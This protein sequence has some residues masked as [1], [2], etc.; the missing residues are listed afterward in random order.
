MNALFQFQVRDVDD[1]RIRDFSRKDIHF[2]VMEKLIDNA[3]LLQSD[4]RF[5]P[6]KLNQRNYADATVG[7]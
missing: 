3:A 1:D 6:D 5:T 2:N 4:A 7:G